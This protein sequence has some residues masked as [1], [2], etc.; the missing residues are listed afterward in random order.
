MVFLVWVALG[1]LVY[2]GYG[3]RHSKLAGI[4]ES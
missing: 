4:K 2:F 3:I 1:T